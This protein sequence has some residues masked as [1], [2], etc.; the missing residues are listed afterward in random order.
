MY[1]LVH[2]TCS[3]EVLCVCVCVCG[4]ERGIT[5]S[6]SLFNYLYNLF[7]ARAQAL[8]VQFGIMALVGHPPLIEL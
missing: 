8:S 1:V 2:V 4:R 3:K 6:R 5:L 7:V